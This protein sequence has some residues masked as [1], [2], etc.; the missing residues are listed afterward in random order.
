MILLHSG[1]FS[2]QILSPRFDGCSCA[3]LVGIGA[4]TA[5][6]AAMG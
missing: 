5:V 3:D 2:V 6:V 1:M 4:G